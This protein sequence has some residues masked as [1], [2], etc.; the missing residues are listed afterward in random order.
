MKPKGI[1]KHFLRVLPMLLPFVT[2]SLADQT[3]ASMRVKIA[4]KTRERV[5]DEAVAKLNEAAR[6]E[7]RTSGKRFRHGSDGLRSARGSARTEAGK[8]ERSSPHLVIDHVE[9]P[10]SRDSDGRARF[11]E[12]LK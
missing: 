10:F 9:R 11:D 6:S 8:D 12:T 2:L 7:N 3:A 1:M 4:A 5:I